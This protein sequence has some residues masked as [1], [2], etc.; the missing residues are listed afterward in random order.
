MSAPSRLWIPDSTEVAILNYALQVITNNPCNIPQEHIAQI[1]K[2]VEVYKQRI[3]GLNLNYLEMGQNSPFHFVCTATPAQIDTPIILYIICIWVKNFPFLAEALKDSIGKFLEKVMAN[4]KGESIVGNDVEEILESNIKRF[5]DTG[6]SLSLFYPQFPQ[7]V[8]E[9]LHSFIRIGV[10]SLPAVEPARLPSLIRRLGVTAK[11][12]SPILENVN[13]A[14]VALLHTLLGKS[15]T[16]PEIIAHCC[17]LLSACDRTFKFHSST[18]VF[19]GEELRVLNPMQ[20]IYL[21]RLSPRWSLLRIL[22][23]VPMRQFRAV[24]FDRFSKLVLSPSSLPEHL[25]IQEWSTLFQIGISLGVYDLT[26]LFKLLEIEM[27]GEDANSLLTFLTT[28]TALLQGYP[29]H[30]EQWGQRRDSLVS[31]F[32]SSKGNSLPLIQAL[33]A[34]QESTSE[35][36]MCIG[37]LPLHNKASEL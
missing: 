23:S 29:F 14:S 35:E 9:I 32:L 7:K 28:M 2:T 16:P 36:W 27:L 4:T 24:D 12:T 6:A 15:D 19:M 8:M 11:M 37:K 10:D 34:F 13:F 1:K 33:D 26:H 22:E 31:D 30:R 5:I 18:L 17:V 21:R 20:S 25:T 3:E